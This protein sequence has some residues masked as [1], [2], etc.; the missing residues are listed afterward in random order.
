MLFAALLT[1]LACGLLVIGVSP[2]GHPPDRDA[3]WR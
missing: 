1:Q 2:F 3:F